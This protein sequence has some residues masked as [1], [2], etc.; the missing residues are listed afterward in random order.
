MNRR[1][2]VS[3]IVHTENHPHSA[4][5][6]ERNELLHIKCPAICLIK[7]QI[8][9]LNAKVIDELEEIRQRKSVGNRL[10]RQRFLILLIVLPFL[11]WLALIY[12]ALNGAALCGGSTCD[13]SSRSNLVY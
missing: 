8:R 5:K 4:K 13:G 10:Y 1:D 11:L 6:F 7:S 12:G 2:S 9:N 3:T